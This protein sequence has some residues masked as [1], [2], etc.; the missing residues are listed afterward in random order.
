MDIIH[1]VN[2]L[3]HM[4]QTTIIG[5]R[6][7]ITSSAA[8]SNY[9]FKSES[10]KDPSKIAAWN[11]LEDDQN[12]SEQSLVAS[13]NVCD[14]P[15]LSAL[16]DRIGGLQANRM[17][18]Y[19]VKQL[20][21]P[22][23]MKATMCT[24]DSIFY[25]SQYDEGVLY[26]NNRIRTYIRNLRQ[27]GSE[28]G[29]GYAMLA[30]FENGKEM[31]VVKVSQSPTDDTLLHE[32]VVGLYGTNK[33]RQYVPNFSYIFGGFKCSPP[34]IDPDTKKVITWCLNNNNN[35]VNYV[36]Y[37]NIAPAISVSEYIETCSGKDFVNIYLQIFYALRIGLK[38]IDFTHY[39]LHYENVLIR[40]PDESKSKKNFQIAYDTE[41]GTEY[42][43]SN[44]IATIIDY[45]FSHIKTD[46]VV[47]STG[48]VVKRGQHYGK[49]GFINYSIFPDR[50]WIVHDLYK[51]LMFCMMKA[52]QHNNRSVMS[53]ASKIF[54]FFNQ[55]EDP[56]VAIKEQQAILFAFPL[57][58]ETKDISPDDL[59]T[60]I[61]SVCN[62]DFISRNR[63]T[64]P[65]LDCEKMCLTE[66][67]IL[68]KIG[69][70]P[71]SRIGIPD[72]I[73]EFHDI[74]SRLQNQGR[75]E[76][77]IRLTREFSY[78]KCMRSHVEKMQVLVRDLIDIRRRFKLVDIRDITI[79]LVLNYN[80]MMIIRSMYVSMGSIIDKTVDLR[81]FAE[82]GKTVAVY[83]SDQE[84]VQMIDNIM[85]EFDRQVR[86][87]IA[88][89]KV[90]FGNNRNYLNI[91]KSDTI[92]A[93]AV[94]RDDRLRWYWEGRNLFDI[95]I[96]SSDVS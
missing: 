70:D 85:D 77:K 54:K 64:D 35:T 86:P 34:M 96:E 66:A 43:T 95:V 65:I 27:I 48:A 73:I 31:F 90:V 46:D 82:I 22:S 51:F 26:M 63:S 32:L 52:S 50:S 53:E 79:D 2:I 37:E 23:V 71:N 55:T 59:A 33:L 94:D 25:T 41:R 56:L 1:D 14:V 20:Y 57:T 11:S 68:N 89:A 49:S 16:R 87:A 69:M 80:T 72:N 60:Y 28:S 3:V 13:M 88:D 93:D 78:M 24:V 81:F 47:D 36:L 91:I 4:S 30:D 19:T 92:V 7:N 40:T 58:A 15:K 10:I 75:E 45:G 67:A 9:N 5:K 39:D 17:K 62:C 44:V 42:I 29:E 8:I 83:Y 74:A 12:Q 6:L 84:A 21:N 76:E 38:V 18:E 61:R